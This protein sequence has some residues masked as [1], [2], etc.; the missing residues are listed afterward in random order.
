MHIRV[1]FLAHEPVEFD[2]ATKFE[3]VAGALRIIRPGNAEVYFGPASWFRVDLVR[4]APSVTAMP[5]LAEDDE[6]EAPFWRDD[7]PAF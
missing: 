5:V 4:P 6:G 2:D 3:V 7:N 1:E